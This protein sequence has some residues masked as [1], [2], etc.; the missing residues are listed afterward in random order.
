V[1]DSGPTT[2]PPVVAVVVVHEPGPWFDEMLA[3]LAAQDYPNLRSV[4]LLTGD[5]LDEALVARIGRQVPSPIVRVVGANPGFGASANEAIR[6]VEGAGFF[7]FLHDDVALERDAVT[8]LVAEIY[9]SNAGIVGPKLLDWDQPSVLQSVGFG[10][11]RFGVALSAVEEGE[12]DQEQHDSVRDV[13]FLPTACLLIRIDLFEELGGFAEDIDFYGD[14]LDLC[15]RA[16]LS[17]ARVVVAP[18]AVARHRGVLPERRPDLDHVARGE[19]HRTRTALSAPSG[20]RLALLLPQHLIVLLVGL[21]VGPFSGHGRQARAAFAAFVGQIVAFPAL[22]GR[23]RRYQRLREVTD[24]ELA[25]LQ[26]R[27]AAQLRAFLRARSALREARHEE[28]GGFAEQTAAKLRERT[29]LATVGVWLAVVVLLLFGSRL[30]ITRGVPI[31][32]D[33]LAWPGEPREPLTTYA[34]GWW[35]IGLG[36]TRAIPTA[37]AELGALATLA[38]GSSGLARTLLVVG[39]LFVG[40]LG[41]WRVGRGIGSERAGQVAMI[42]YFAA[43]LGAAA[44]G[45]G[46]VPGVVGFALVPWVVHLL[47]RLGRWRPAAPLGD[48]RRAARRQLADL[49]LLG[50]IVAIGAAFVPLLPVVVLGIAVC[51]V[52]ASPLAGEWRGALRALA[53]AAGGV[54][55][56]AVLHL[57]WATRLVPFGRPWWTFA[58]LPPSVPEQRGLVELAHI[59]IGPH[60]ITVLALG[61]LVPM[62][63]ALV[64]AR[65]PRLAWAVRAGVLAAAGLGTAWLVDRGTIEG[66][67]GTTLLFLAPYVL[68]LAIGAGCAVAAYEQDVPATQL[69]WRQPLGLV[70]VAAVAVGIVPLIPAVAGGRWEQRRSDLPVLLQLLPAEQAGPNRTLWIGPPEQ[71]PVRSWPLAP[72][73]AYAI[74]E[75]DV[76]T[77]ATLWPEEPTEG[78]ELVAEALDLAASGR[79]DRLGRLLASSAIRY[80]MVPVSG[81]DPADEDTA[82]ADALATDSQRVIVSILDRQLD[83]EAFEIGDDRLEVFRNISALPERA[84]VRGETAEASQQAGPDTIIR[85]D[86]TEATPVLPGGDTE[87]EGPVDG[88]AVVLSGSADDHWH[89]EVDGEELER[90]VAFGWANGWDLAAPGQGVLEYRTA[91]TRH[92]VVALQAA[93]WIAVIAAIVLL[94]RDR[95]PRRKPAAAGDEPVLSL[96][97]TPMPEE[98]RRTVPGV[99]DPELVAI[100]LAQPWRKRP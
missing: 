99:D 68:A 46:S 14:D 43:P 44:A 21:V 75:T 87:G 36:A 72:G 97:G 53:A 35:A 23:R 52:I 29:S 47:A 50:V 19:R 34:G 63:V 27:G 54:V 78:E 92:A 98:S 39:S 16:H 31:V 59:E 9:R 30:L 17:G 2:A 8:Q 96:E 67:T 93:L 60:R 38:F 83:L 42:V 81:G 69:T 4:F 84:A 37:M 15:W 64:V 88:D 100:E 56:A 91:L 5:D 6:L 77:L 57:P 55:L 48:S 40:V 74:I 86:P 70:A 28:R 82:A 49:L 85:Y 18:S 7:L 45:V 71:L 80:V 61:L 24:G 10:A 41:A 12:L 32:G 11:D 66:G 62:F 13:F 33:L 94:R 22:I 3:G 65:G 76:P 79:T 58:Q 1:T 89:L 73:L 26:V 51:A 25:S 90:R 20:G 95:I